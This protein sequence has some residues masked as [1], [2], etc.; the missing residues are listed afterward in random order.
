MIWNN[1]KIGFRTLLKYKGFSFVNIIGLSV[2]IASVLIVVLHIQFEFSFDDF[3]KK[4]DNLF[5]VAVQAFKEGEPEHKSHVFVPP[6][7][8]AL[9]ETFPDIKNYTRYSTGVNQI[10]IHGNKAIKLKNVVYADSTFFNLFS[11]KILSG[12]KEKILRSPYNIVLTTGAAKLIFD[13]VDVVGKTI[14]ISGKDYVISGLTDNPPKNSSI[15][16]NALISF[17]TL[18]SEPGNYMDWN[19]GNRYITFIELNENVQPERLTQKFPGFMWKH[20]NEKLASIN[21]RFDASLQPMNEIHLNYESD[22]NTLKTNLYIFSAIAFL[23]LMVASINFINLSTAYS[24]RRAKEIGV[25]KVLGAGRNSLIKQFLSETI[26]ISFISMILALL[27]VHLIS[28]FYTELSGRDL[29]LPFLFNSTNLINLAVLFLFTGVLAGIY[30]SIILSKLKPLKALHST[31]ELKSERK[32]TIR[33]ALVV[34]QFCISIIM[35]LSTIIV[36]Q[37]LSYI[38]NTDLG[39]NKENVIFIPLQGE[40]SVENISLLKSKLTELPGV[41]DVSGSSAIP[42]LGLTRNGY[43]PQG[44]TTPMMINVIDVDENFFNVYDL[45]IKSGEFFKREL[46]TDDDTYIINSSLASTLGW[47]NAVDKMIRRNGDHRVIG[48]VEDFNFSSLYEDVKPLIITN[49]GWENKFD[50]LSIKYQSADISKF[51]SDVKQITN[52]ILPAIPFEFHF[53]DETLERLYEK[54]EI[55]Y[56]LF[57]TLSLIAIIIAAMGLFS[58]AS[59]S[60]DQRTKEIGIRK[61]LGATSFS[62]VSLLVKE[63]LK[64]VLIAILFAWPVTYYFI[65]KWLDNFAYKSEISAFPFILSG[66]IAMLIAVITVSYKSIKTANVNPIKS[67]RYE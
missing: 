19:G 59:Y 57:F 8:P 48:V 64:L 40:G 41:N 46:T 54:E 31:A 45:K 9:K 65:N 17:S 1:F 66:L 52:Q 25:K 20:L 32:L 61:V 67:L 2:G 24:F 42:G 18:Y 55:F 34:F 27:L 58:L 7:G 26:L 16:F 6:V 12:D 49:R 22:S 11:F 37:Q 62:L 23:I 63:Y 10:I 50:Y 44:H 14:E 33:N 28:P 13:D 38:K 4:S 29:E 51:I 15:Q 56:R 30:P 53:V 3:H 39:F 5:R 60:A 47:N 36:N 43:F 21:V 35:I